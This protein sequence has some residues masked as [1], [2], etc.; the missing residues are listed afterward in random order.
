MKWVQV[1][2]GTYRLVEDNDSR[3]EVKLPSKEG[4]PNIHIAPPWK[5][6]EEG[7]TVGTP[8][9]QS[10]YSD[11]FISE[12]EH[13]MKTEPKWKRWEESRRKSLAKDKPA[14][15]KKQSAS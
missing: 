11:K 10:D 12:R 6:Y 3:P 13:T 2:V 5:K 8:D 1:K 15:R 4:V 9:S 14:W 7:V